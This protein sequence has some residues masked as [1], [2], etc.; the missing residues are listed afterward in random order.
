MCTE[1]QRT[2]ASMCS[3]HICALETSWGNWTK[4]GILSPYC[5]LSLRASIL[6]KH[7]PAWAIPLTLEGGEKVEKA[8]MLRMPQNKKYPP[9]SSCRLPSEI[10]VALRESTFSASFRWSK[11]Q[12]NCLQVMICEGSLET[13]CKQLG[14]PITVK[15]SYYFFFSLSKISN[16][17]FLAVARGKNR[18]FPKGCD[19]Q[20]WA[21]WGAWPW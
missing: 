3:S 10:L 19:Q 9:E 11:K 4:W 21:H 8:K 14:S 1:S 18:G 20:N 12:V 5:E 16:C 17:A 7:L 15:P 13:Q 6:K 2:T